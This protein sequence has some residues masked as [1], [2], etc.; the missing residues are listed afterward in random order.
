MA[1]QALPPLPAPDLYAGPW[2]QAALF[3]DSWVEGKDGALTLV[4]VVDSMIVEVGPDG[5]PSVSQSLGLK[6]V[7]MLKSGQARGRHELSLTLEE[8]SGIRHAP[9]HADLFFPGDEQ[10]VNLLTEVQLGV[11]EGL[12]WFDVAVNG[13]LLTR[14]PYRVRFQRSPAA[15]GQ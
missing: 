13:R 2:L 10:G 8:P 7:L 11:Q 14:V 1:E 3:C 9:R 15:P 5:A 12:F 4:R 6:L